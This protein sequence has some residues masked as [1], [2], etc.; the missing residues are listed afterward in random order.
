[1]ANY[2]RDGRHVPRQIMPELPYVILSVLDSGRYSNWR[3]DLSVMRWEFRD[4]SAQKKRT[5]EVSER[6]MG[7]DGF[8]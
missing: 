1:M 6:G 8:N 3:G 7:T 5:D 4:V 2:L